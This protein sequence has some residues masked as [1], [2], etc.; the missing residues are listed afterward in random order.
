MGC[1]VSCFLITVLCKR[2]KTDF[3]H[4]FVNSLS[5]YF[6]ANQFGSLWFGLRITGFSFLPLHQHKA[7][8]NRPGLM[9][10]LVLR[11]CRPLF[12]FSLLYPS[13]RSAAALLGALA[14]FA[15]LRRCVFVGCSA[16]RTDQMML[17]ESLKEPECLCLLV[18]TER[19]DA[20]TSTPASA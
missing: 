9:V 7:R 2:K 14:V 16:I 13:L 10:S 18:P 5:F 15:G 8:P 11:N 20:K 17:G 12:H 19:A 1:C 3:S 6:C 4:A